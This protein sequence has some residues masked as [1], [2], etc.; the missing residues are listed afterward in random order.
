MTLEL[1]AEDGGQRQ[2]RQCLRK[3]LNTTNG[4]VRVASA[5]VTDE[6]LLLGIMN[7]KIQL[8]TSLLRMDIV[9]GST[10]LRALRSL[11]KSGVQCRC[12]SG[13][14]LHAKVYIFGEESAVVTSANL[15]WSALD[16]NIEVGVCLTGNQVQEVIAWFDA[17]WAK[18]KALDLPKLSQW[19][20]ETEAL[21]RAYA[22][23]RKE[24]GEK[25]KLP[26][27]ARPSVASPTRF[28]D[29]MNNARRF[30]VCNT[31]RRYSPDG[32]DEALMRQTQYAAVWED[33]NYPGHLERVRPGDAIFMFA[34]KVGIVGVGRANGHHQVLQ[35]GD[36]E[37]ISTSYNRDAEWRVPVDDWLAW[38][39]HDEDAY[40]WQMPNA[41]FLDVSGDHY[42]QMREGIRG[43][44]LLH[45]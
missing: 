25:P 39:E 42:R 24:A 45:S 11:V 20:K 31:N 40:D 38:A 32:T 3:L 44:Y 9:S 7:R 8:L 16:K 18:G 10:S 43:H 5:Y 17:F 28:R 19:E 12:L 13:P 4:P 29:L 14:R 15:T 36:S 26:N 22:A 34:K 2:H 37:R 30:F 35:P 21:R 33:F 41:S 6:D 1:I 27:E 23:L